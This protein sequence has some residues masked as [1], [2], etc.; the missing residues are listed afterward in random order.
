MESLVFYTSDPNLGAT[1]P[2][3]VNSD[4]Q[5]LYVKNVSESTETDLGFYIAPATELGAENTPGSFP[6]ETDYE[7]LLTWGSIANSGGD[8]GGL[9]IKYNNIEYVVH[10]TSGAD[11]NTKISIGD[12]T[13]GSTISFSYKFITPSTVSSRRFYVDLFLE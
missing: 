10:R 11:Y 4:W 1:Q 6:P 9:Y 5:T 3:Q 8:S 12:L 2:V 7:D 13:A